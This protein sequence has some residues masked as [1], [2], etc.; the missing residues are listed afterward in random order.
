MISITI[1]ILATHL[2]SWR[3]FQKR[4]LSFAFEDEEE[5][6]GEDDASTSLP[7]KKVLFSKCIYAF[8]IIVEFVESTP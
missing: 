6:E 3:L 8:Y 7:P 2:L 4:V 1:T 5:E